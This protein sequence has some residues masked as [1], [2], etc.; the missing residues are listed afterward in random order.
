ML[1]NW[2]VMSLA[3]LLCYGLFAFLYK[4]AAVRKMN[5]VAVVNLST[6]TVFGLGLAV[7]VV[8]GFVVPE[9]PSLLFLAVGNG[10]FFTLGSVLKMESLRFLPA[11]IAF[12]LAKTNILFVLLA[13]VAIFGERP[14]LLQV[15]GI[16]S[17]VGML[18]IAR[19]R[20][21]LGS[22]CAHPCSRGFFLAL[23]G[24]FCTAL[25]VSLGRTAARSD[26][27]RI[28]YVTCSYG[29]AA[30]FSLLWSRGVGASPRTLGRG[31]AALGM[32]A[33]LLNFVG[34]LCVLQA[35]AVGP[36]SAA[37]PV[38][39]MSILVP[40]ALSALMFKERLTLRNL[41]ALLLALAAAILIKSG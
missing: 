11:A 33:G 10:L 16:A 24:A 36:L 31:G 2:F 7:L 19:R 20:P 5:S 1:N 29:L 18:L 40:I 32:A 27:D 13:A 35:F 8:R 38:M 34:Y 3:A 41:L 9:R 37:Q 12:S 17:A 22:G 4:V 26:L 39:S 28:L 15:A 6:A 30:F 23:G 14:S 21:A 25:T